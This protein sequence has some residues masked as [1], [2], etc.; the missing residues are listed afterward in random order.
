MWCDNCL[1]VLPLRAGAIAWAVIIAIYS[2]IGGLFLLLLGQWVFFTYP[3][4]FIYGGIGMAVTAI[5]VITAIAFS[6]RSY[7]F[8]RAMQF[9]WPFII[10]ICGIR[11]ILM[12]VQLNRGKDK[13]QWQCDNDLQPWPAAVNNSNSYSMPSEICIVG[14]SGFNTAVI[15]GLLVDL[16]FQM[17]MF[18]L[19][20]RFCARLVHY[21]GMKGPFGNG[22][23]SA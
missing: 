21:S 2:L 9:I 17:Y 16:A 7:V 22:Y 13:I 20:W 18:F 3:E 5:A 15:I 11:A 8:A 10:L 14:F 6:T 23:Y 12:I 19:T 4:W 1:L